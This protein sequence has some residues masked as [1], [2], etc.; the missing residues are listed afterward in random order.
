MR[1]NVELF[2]KYSKP[3]LAQIE[4]SG[5]FIIFCRKCK[6]NYL[7]LQEKTVKKFSFSFCVRAR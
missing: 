4:N 1:A 6:Q 5:I 7:I 2:S 3:I